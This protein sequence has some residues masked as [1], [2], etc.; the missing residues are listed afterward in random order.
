MLK[1]H[2]LSRAGSRKKQGSNNRY[3]ARLKL[4]KWHASISKMRNDFLHKLSNHL[5]NL[6]D[7]IVVENLVLRTMSQ[8]LNYGKSIADNGSGLFRQYL[9]FKLLDRDKGLIT[10]DKWFANSKT[11]SKCGTKNDE[12]YLGFCFEIKVNS[13]SATQELIA[14]YVNYL[15]HNGFTALHIACSRNHLPIVKALLLHPQVNVNIRNSAGDNP[16]HIACKSNHY[17]IVLVMEELLKM[18][19][20]NIHLKKNQHLSPLELAAEYN[21]H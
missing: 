21:H 1:K 8:A 18:R 14:L 11:C 7:I 2:K 19:S 15:T 17:G 12:L 4:A 16:L 13:N 20:I 3:K 9:K 5:A 6:Y 10:L